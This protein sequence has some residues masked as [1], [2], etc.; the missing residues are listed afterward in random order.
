M[1]IQTYRLGANATE[2]T[3]GDVRYLQ[4]YN[5]LVAA[6][7]NGKLYL[8]SRWDYSVTTVKHV[9][10]F[11]GYKSTELRKMVKAGEVEVI[12]LEELQDA[13]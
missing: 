3:I 11:T 4:S 1:K 7:K 8:G 5:S 10:Q 2:L 9:C 12:D 13:E 6:Y